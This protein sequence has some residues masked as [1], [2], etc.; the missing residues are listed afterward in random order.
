MSK[1]GNGYVKK[2]ESKKNNWWNPRFDPG[3]GNDNAFSFIFNAIS[4]I[5]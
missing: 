4:K 3:S 5:F 2:Q 1:R